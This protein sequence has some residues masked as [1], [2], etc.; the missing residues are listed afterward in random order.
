MLETLLQAFT[1]FFVTVE[2]VALAPLF[3]ALT[4]AMDLAQ[5]RRIAMRATVVAAVVLVVFAIGGE[6]VLKTLGISLPALRIA[7]GVLL[8]VLAIEMVFAHQSGLRFT[9]AGEQAEAAERQDIAVF[10]LAIPLIAGPATITAV[11]LMMGE[12]GVSVVL[13][14]AVLMILLVVLAI[15]LGM[16]LIASRVLELLG[17][18]GI[19]VVSRV[20]G[21]LLAA[22]A[23]Q[24]VIDGLKGSGLF[25]AP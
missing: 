20:L 21:I 14:A 16:L 13:R 19:N 23:A 2:P 15:T 18:T 24:F 8:F 9:T 7:G 1:T 22:L 5:K 12:S 6:F 4:Q 10:P 11:I 25:L 17:I 3:V